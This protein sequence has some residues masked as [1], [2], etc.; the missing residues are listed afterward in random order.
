MNMAICYEF[1]K[2][3]T[4]AQVAARSNV[5]EKARWD[6]HPTSELVILALCSFEKAPSDIEIACLRAEQASSLVES[7]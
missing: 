6:I 2:G 4:A 7:M 3:G 5:D 1:V